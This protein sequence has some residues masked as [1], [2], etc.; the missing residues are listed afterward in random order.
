MDK[1]LCD[2]RILGRDEFVERIIAEAD[3]R[4]I[5]QISISERKIKAKKKSLM[6]AAKKGCILRN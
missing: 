2:E 4:I 1:V 6:Y 5:G 3:K